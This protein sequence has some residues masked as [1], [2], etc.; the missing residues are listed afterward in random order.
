MRPQNPV[1]QLR[2]NSSINKEGIV[3]SLVT[4]EEP[5]Q[6]ELPV[7]MDGANQSAADIIMEATGGSSATANAENSQPPAPTEGAPALQP[8]VPF[9]T[10][11][12]FLQPAIYNGQS[13]PSDW[14]AQYKAWVQLQK[15]PEQNAF[16]ILPVVQQKFGLMGYQK[17]QK[18]T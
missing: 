13:K 16:V 3:Q 7:V 18:Q 2:S 12:A 4:T 8:Q 9:L 5:T 17:A 15:L 14:V 10:A 1:R 11:T 6:S